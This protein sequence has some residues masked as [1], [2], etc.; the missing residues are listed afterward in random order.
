MDSTVLN[1]SSGI[2]EQRCYNRSWGESMSDSAIRKVIFS[3][4]LD[5]I[6][7]IFA[8][9]NF[10]IIDCNIQTVVHENTYP[11]TFVSVIVAENHTDKYFKILIEYIFD[12]HDSGLLDLNILH[13]EQIEER[14]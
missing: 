9:K 13:I 4:L 3:M 10:R 14:I 8:D 7:N 1:L 5:Y 2:L 11:T 12:T 6:Q